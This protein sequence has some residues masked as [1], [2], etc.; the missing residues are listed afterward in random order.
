MV[1]TSSVQQV[2]LSLSKGGASVLEIAEQLGLD[3]HEVYGFI[4]ESLTAASSRIPEEKARPR[5]SMLRAFALD[6]LPYLFDI[7]TSPAADCGHSAA[8]WTVP[9]FLAT[10]RS[11]YGIQ[12]SKRTLR[13]Y[14][15][16][17]GFTFEQQLS[18][19]TLTQATR[20]RVQVLRLSHP[21]SLIY[22]VVS[23][24]LKHHFREAHFPGVVLLALSA[25][26]RVAAVARRQSRVS[27]Q[28]RTDFLRDLIKLHPTQHV[29][30]LAHEVGPAQQSL[31]ALERI[32]RRLHFVWCPA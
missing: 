26:G 15:E 17:L 5:R 22:L 30:V 8:L 10:A 11:Q 27:T 20:E 28:F 18:R 6:D 25:T 12:I 24:P 23:V 13:R 1:L 2:V 29:I 9:R 4:L 21:R 16:K 19:Y 7:L 31:L 32:E 3:F 14:Q